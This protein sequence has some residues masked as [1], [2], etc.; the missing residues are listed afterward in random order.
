MAL[1]KARVQLLNPDTGAVVAEV[2][3]LTTGSCVSYV[4]N[5]P[6]VSDFRGI[7]AGTTFKE[8][9]NVSMS[10]ILDKIL[11]PYEEME[12]ESIS[13]AEGKAV[14]SD[15]V[16]YQEKYT[17]I[18]NFTFSAKVKVGNVG[19]LKFVL[20]RYNNI[21]GDIKTMES[22]IK[23]TPG[24]EY[25][26]TQDVAN[27]SDDTSLQLVVTDGT[28]NIVSPTLDFKFIY[29]MYVGYC[30]LS[31]I[32]GIIDTGVE[33]NTRKAED[34]FNNL[35]LNKS[36]LIEKRLIPMQDLQSIIV[37]DPVY[38][39]KRYYPCIL[40]PNTWS[41][42]LNI[43]DCNDDII[44]GSYYYNTKI[45][46]KPDNMEIHAG[47][48]TVYACRESYNPQLAATGAISYQFEVGKGSVDYKGK[49]VPNLTGFNVM[50]NVPLD[51]RTEVSLYDDLFTIE[52]KYDGLV[53]YVDEYSSYYRYDKTNDVWLSTNQETLFGFTDPPLDLGKD[54]DTFIDMS[55]GHIYQKY[56]NIR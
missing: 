9:D 6:T 23:A 25:L 5:D 1:E 22:S 27:I 3:I 16:F 47:Q 39:S 53:V 35:I 17:N 19:S 44:T 54:G 12:I 8:E 49:G 34:Y 4:N 28:T 24:S 45:S 20:K 50:N 2:D 11:Y 41:K 26:Y 36:P 7:P 51:L 42:I 46:I 10:D 15:T 29:P 32:T 18:P 33:I 13:N 56:K 21:N 37:N 48:Y 43:F 14:T 40:Y 55:T 31:L 38:T 30:D 52:Y